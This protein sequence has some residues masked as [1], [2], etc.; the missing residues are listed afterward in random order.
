MLLLCLDLWQHICYQNWQRLTSDL[1]P[2]GP[3]IV[4]SDDKIVDSKNIELRSGST[5][6]L[7]KFLPGTYTKIHETL[8]LHHAMRLCKY[9]LA[10]NISRKKC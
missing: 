3:N 1:A 10:K 7:H 9:T 8:L 5:L 2:R 6:T 4:N